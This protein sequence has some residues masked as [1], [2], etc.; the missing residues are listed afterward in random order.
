[1]KKKR[2]RLFVNLENGGFRTPNCKH[3]RKK[4]IDFRLPGYMTPNFAKLGGCDV[5]FTVRNVHD[6][7]DQAVWVFRALKKITTFVVECGSTML[8]GTGIF[9][10]WWQ[11]KYQV[12]QSAL[13]IP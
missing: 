3:K 12:I 4:D 13:F 8:H 10:R 5:C 11:L 7:G 9:T 1:M 2:G 6:R